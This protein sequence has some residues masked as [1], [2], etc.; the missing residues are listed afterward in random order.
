[1]VMTRLRL[2]INNMN[3]YKAIIILYHSRKHNIDLLYLAFCDGAKGKALW[4]TLI[5]IKVL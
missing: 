1:M 2:N 4:N 3:F 5:I